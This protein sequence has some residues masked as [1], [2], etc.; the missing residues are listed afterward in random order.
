MTF[1][2]AG[3][4]GTAASTP[5]AFS[6][7]ARAAASSHGHIILAEELIW[8]PSAGV[9]IPT[10]TLGVTI[11]LS[12]LPLFSTTGDLCDSTHCPVPAGPFSVNLQQPLPLMTPPVRFALANLTLSA[13]SDLQ[14]F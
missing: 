6:P 4:S 1:G 11:L 2:L 3:E 13:D 7:S 12:G 8:L 5:L 14:S 10:G 9:A